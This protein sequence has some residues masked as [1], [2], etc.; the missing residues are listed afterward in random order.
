MTATPTH[1]AVSADGTSMF[2]VE[3]YVNTPELSAGRG[4]G[5]SQ[6]LSANGPYK[7]LFRARSKSEAGAGTGG[8]AC[9]ASTVVDAP[10]LHVLAE[11]AGSPEA[12]SPI[13]SAAA[14]A[15]PPPPA[16]AAATPA[17]TPAPVVPAP[18]S[19]PAPAPA[20]P[21]SVHT[22]KKRR[23]PSPLIASLSPASS[24]APLDSAQA[25]R[26]SPVPSTNASASSSSHVD[27][28]PP[29][30]QPRAKPVN[31]GGNSTTAKGRKRKEKAPAPVPPPARAVQSNGNGEQGEQRYE[32]R[33]LP[34]QQ[35]GSPFPATAELRETE[36]AV[37]SRSRNV[38]QQ[39]NRAGGLKDND[40][41]GSLSPPA[42]PAD[43]GNYDH[44]ESYDPSYYKAEPSSAGNTV[45]VG[46]QSLSP[47]P[48]ESPRPSPSVVNHYPG[49]ARMTSPALKS[50]S[51]SETPGTKPRM[52]T[53]LIEDRRNGTDE[54]A[55]VHVPLKTIGEEGCLWADAKDVCA[56]LQSGPSRIDGVCFFLRAP[57]GKGRSIDEFLLAQVPPRCSRCAESIDRYFCVYL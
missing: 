3:G 30:R 39:R 13:S 34:R 55:E 54:L 47:P 49:S 48:K 45:R 37:Q 36:P 10:A 4:G 6:G 23:K 33:S 41:G 29:P 8:K 2:C 22:S 9:A 11:A 14:S 7:S 57:A 21:T 56:A 32:R 5:L 28:S 40:V 31:G 38:Q 53:L 16:A 35:S 12:Q 44:A 20:L 42:A 51:R 25:L 50:S 15:S 43:N 17:P 1:A 19:V 26:P 24:G 52:V 27:P 18:A 46:G